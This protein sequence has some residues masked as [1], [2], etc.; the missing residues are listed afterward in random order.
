MRYFHGAMEKY[1]FLFCFGVPQSSEIDAGNR[2]AEIL[3]VMRA[4]MHK[5]PHDRWHQTLPHHYLQGIFR[6]KASLWPWNSFSSGTWMQL[7]L[8]NVGL[9]GFNPAWSSGIKKKKKSGRRSSAWFAC[10]IHFSMSL[11]F[12]FF[13]WRMHCVVW[14]RD[15]C[16]THEVVYLVARAAAG[17]GVA[18]SWWSLNRCIAF[19]VLPGKNRKRQ[20]NFLLMASFIFR[21]MDI[22]ASWWY[23]LLNILVQTQGRQ[24]S[25]YACCN[26]YPS[27]TEMN[28]QKLFKFTSPNS[29][30]VRG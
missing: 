29:E 1:V 11:V 5:S 17:Y 30:R 28:V 26:I 10:F 16:P 6:Y 24:D 20:L 19:L 12:F 9:V 13:S 7:L 8:P 14:A 27:S 23:W 18:Y 3:F 25:V 4:W 15:I 21:R 2:M 22:W